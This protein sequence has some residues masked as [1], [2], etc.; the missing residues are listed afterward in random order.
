[1]SLSNGKDTPISSANFL[2]AKGLSM[3]M[4]RTAL[5]VCSNLAISA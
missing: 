2:L 3:L 5:L 1:M 4:P